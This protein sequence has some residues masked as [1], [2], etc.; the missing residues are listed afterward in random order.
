MRFAAFR[1]GD[2]MKFTDHDF[3]VISK[4][5]GISSIQSA[6]ARN[7]LVYL[8]KIYNNMIDCSSI[9]NGMNLNAPRRLLRGLSY[10]F[11]LLYSTD[12]YSFK[13]VTTRICYLYNNNNSLFDLFFDRMGTIRRLTCRL[14][15]YN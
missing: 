1:I 9:V 12:S 8:G 13:S 14:L 10:S 5:L 2:P 6:V 11:K 15:E 3:S 7:N 4:K